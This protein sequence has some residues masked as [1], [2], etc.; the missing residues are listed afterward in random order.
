MAHIPRLYTPTRLEPGPLALEGALAR[1]VST[2]LR[3]KESDRF[4]VFSGDGKEWQVRIEN[5]GRQ[6]VH[7]T[8]EEELRSSPLQA[9]QLELAVSIVRANRMD[10]AIEKCTEAGADMIQP[11]TTDYANR[12]SADSRS[13]RERWERIAIEAT[14]QC[15][16]LYVPDILEP[17]AFSEWLEQRHDTVFFG[18]PAGIPWES[19][20]A[21]IPAEGTLSFVVGPEGGF[22]P[23]ETEALRSANAVG[24]C[25]GPYT[26][27]TETGALVA[28]ALVR[29]SA[30]GQ[31]GK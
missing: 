27:R 8:V 21:Q 20:R 3:L 24:V 6:R 13:R 29:S 25:L 19:A 17:L 15:G 2:V 22:S 16:R 9:P 30:V 26:L 4:L 11:I 14:E 1:R 31:Q 23:Q 28:A 12:G 18:D 10:W 7:V 5:I